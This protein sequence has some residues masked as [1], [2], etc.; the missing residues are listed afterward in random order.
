MFLSRH[1][2]G[3][4]ERKK[5]PR[6][7]VGGKQSVQRLDVKADLREDAARLSQPTPEFP[8]QDQLRAYGDFAFL[9]MRSDFHRDVPLHLARLAIQPAIDLGFY[10]VFHNDGIPR[11]GVTWAF[12][13]P[14]AE[15]R[16]T[17]GEVLKPAEWRSGPNMWVIEI[18]APYGQGT[19]AAVVKWLRH[20]LPDGIQTVKYQRIDRDTGVKRVIA[21]NRVKG[22][23]WGA[24]L[25][26]QQ[27]R[28]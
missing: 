23:H 13:G 7:K 12:L 4:E 1:V 11:Y 27:A 22:A 10:K 28:G 16:L 19:A 24:H 15:A 14:E 3:I 8:T 9:Y 25:I 21:V 18:I 2:V 6:K 17:R 5:A 20:N 26:E